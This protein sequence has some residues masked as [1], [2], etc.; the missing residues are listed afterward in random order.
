MSDVTVATIML[1]SI[2]ADGSINAVGQYDPRDTVLT[3]TETQPV[4]FLGKL[5]MR[6]A[7]VPNRDCGVQFKNCPTG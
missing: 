6:A 5:D 3:W 1:A 2:F 4:R 7:T